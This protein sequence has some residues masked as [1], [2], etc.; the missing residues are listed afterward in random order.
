MKFIKDFLFSECNEEYKRFS[1]SLLPDTKNILGV[2]LPKLRKFAKEIYKNHNWNKFLNLK[3]KYFEET[4]LQGM[5]IGLAENPIDH[6]DDF[7]KKIDN[8]SICDSFCSGLKFATSNQQQS[9]DFIQKYLRSKNEFEL[10]FTYVMLL[11]YFIN[12]NYIDKVF[13]ITDNYQKNEY[14]ANLAVAWTLSICFTKYPLKTFQFLKI[15]KLDNWTYNKTIQKICES[16]KVDKNI[17]EKI[18]KL[19]RV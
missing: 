5:V 11:N 12:D 2:R 4:M 3:P 10:R 14:Y 17:K 7:I 13:E 8:W 6:I 1:S 19:K 18:K 9:W 15:T 16:N